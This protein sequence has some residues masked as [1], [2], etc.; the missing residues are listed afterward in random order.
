MV[1]QQAMQLEATKQ[2]NNKKMD[3]PG[4]SIRKMRPSEIDKVCSIVSKEIYEN[5]PVQEIREWVLSTGNYKTLYAPWYVATQ[6]GNNEI[7]GC[8]RYMAYD[9]DF[10]EKQMILAITLLA[11]DSSYQN[12]GVGTKLVK[13]SLNRLSKAWNEKGFKSVLLMVEA[14]ESNAIAR[15]FYKKIL[16]EPEELII[17]DVWSEDEGTVFYYK[18]TQQ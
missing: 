10:I 1:F 12:S 4:I 15:N 17:K 2:M 5:A 6:K 11:V 16:S 14:D 9:F 8:I 13:T 3:K 18:K 7:V